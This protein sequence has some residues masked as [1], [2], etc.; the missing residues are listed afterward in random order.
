LVPEKIAFIECDPVPS[1]TIMLAA[2]PMVNCVAPTIA[3][4]PQPVS[5]PASQKTTEPGVT[6]TPEETTVA[7]SAIGVPKATAVTSDPDEVTASVVV[8]VA[9]AKAGLPGM[10]ATL[11][12]TMKKKSFLNCRTGKF[13]SAA[14]LGR[15]GHR[16][17]KDPPLTKQATKRSRE[18]RITIGK[19]PFIRSDINL[20][21]VRDNYRICTTLRLNIESIWIALARL[22]ITWD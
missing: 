12:V 15:V 11:A 19:E 3:S 14:A 13:L 5:I 8:E 1:L 6:G 4:G 7:V 20:V 21:V 10:A 9:V 17:S 2:P 22:I 18:N 16:T